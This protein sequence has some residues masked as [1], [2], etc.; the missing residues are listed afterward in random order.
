MPYVGNPPAVNF[1]DVPAIQEFNGTGSLTT[2]TLNRTVASPQSIL[3]SVDGVIQNADDSYTVPDGVTLTF[4]APPSSGTSNI[5]VNYL[6]LVAGSVVP[7]DGT[8][9]QNMFAAGL[10]LG[11]GSYKGDTGGGVADIIRVHE[12]QL[13]TNV[14]IDANTNGLCAGPLTLATGVTIT[15]S[16]GATM[17][18]A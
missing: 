2:F 7:A 18:I 8:I 5:F 13:D 9:T 3:V 17:V 6:G 10:V 14:T 12:K 1:A 11:G 15:V 16:T 4:T